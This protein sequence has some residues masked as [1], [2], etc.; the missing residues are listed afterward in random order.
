MKII[1]K[2]E[3]LE[4]KLSRLLGVGGECVVIQ[5]MVEIDSKMTECALRV[6]PYDNS[7]RKALFDGTDVLD[8]PE[9]YKSVHV[10]ELEVKML[11]HKNIIQYFDNSF[12]V[13][14]GNLCHV[15]GS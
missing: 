8:S 10:R 4:L 15:T 12:E 9:V 7:A 6:A 2:N 13:I 11:N 3:N 1:L 14:D 5:K